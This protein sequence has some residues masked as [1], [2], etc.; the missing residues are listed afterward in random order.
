MF[1]SSAGNARHAPAFAAK[2]LAMA[3]C[4]A[5]WG[6]C[7]LIASQL[8]LVANVIGMADAPGTVSNTDF[9]R[10][11]AS[12]AW[13]RMARKREATTLQ[14]FD[15]PAI[16]SRRGL[17]GSLS[18]RLIRIVVGCADH[19]AQGHALRASHQRRIAGL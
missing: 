19:T 5:G 11:L 8:D 18:T 1:P 13:A 10:S 6:S 14:S 2:P 17:Q 15:G 4:R 16:S 3:N 7:A 12:L 9:M